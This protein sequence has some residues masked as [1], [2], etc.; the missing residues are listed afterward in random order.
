MC[1]CVCD[2]VCL[3]DLTNQAIITDVTRRLRTTTMASAADSK[4][5]REITFRVQLDGLSFYAELEPGEAKDAQTS[6][7][8]ELAGMW[9]VVYKEKKKTG[10]GAYD[11]SVFLFSLHVKANEEIRGIFPLEKTFKSAGTA[12]GCQ[13]TFDAQKG[14]AWSI[15]NLTVPQ[16]WCVGGIVMP[17]VALGLKSGTINETTE[18]V[19]GTEDCLDLHYSGYWRGCGGTLVHSYKPNKVTDGQAVLV[20]V[21]LTGKPTPFLHQSLDHAE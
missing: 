11:V 15:A 21:T 18:L 16:G 8:F 9:W 5:V 7:P 14:T 10:D 17:Q 6:E 3:T 4:Y 20:T 2:S 1:V 13:H 19:L 12:A